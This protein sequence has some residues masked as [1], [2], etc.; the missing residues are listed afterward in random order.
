VTGYGGG[1]IRQT[2]HLLR[3]RHIGW[4]RHG[5]ATVEF[6]LLDRFLQRILIAGSEHERCS[7]ARHRLRGGATDAGRRS[8]DDNNLL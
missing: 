4:D 1:L 3:F 6:H 5:T 7:A 8:C 2:L